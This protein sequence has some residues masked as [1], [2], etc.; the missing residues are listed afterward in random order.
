MATGR[1][2]FVRQKELKSDIP[3]YQTEDSQAKI[4][5]RLK[6]EMVWLM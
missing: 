4:D 5:V 3:I 2:G 1:K 6:D